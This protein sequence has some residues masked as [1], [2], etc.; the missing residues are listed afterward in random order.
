VPTSLPTMT[1]TSVR[2]GLAFD[3]LCAFM[4]PQ[5][6]TV[7]PTSVPTPTPT[8][9]PTP[10]PTSLPTLVPSPLPTQ[11]PIPVSLAREYTA[12][13]RS[14]HRA[15]LRHRR[16][17]RRCPPRACR[18]RCQRPYRLPCPRTCPR[19]FPLPSQAQ[20]VAPR[21]PPLAAAT[22][23]VRLSRQPRPPRRSRR[24]LQPLHPPM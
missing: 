8:L 6:P 12:V 21:A 10:T 22:E 20:Y 5:V 19:A 13:K 23:P 16:T 17:C 9:P 18:P 1:P 3:C 7:P 15:L 4:L 24:L 11:I 2:G 14:R